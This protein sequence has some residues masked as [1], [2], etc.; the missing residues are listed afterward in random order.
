VSNTNQQIGRD[1]HGDFTRQVFGTLRANSRLENPRGI[2]YALT[3]QVCGATGQTV[4]QDE[5]AR[6]ITPRCGN[7]GCGVKSTDTRRTAE[8][9]VDLGPQDVRG[10]LEA[11]A[12]AEAIARGGE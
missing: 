11:K 9:G 4:S 10:R 7:S 3:C 6:G 12:R 5:L 2:R 8:F 1:I